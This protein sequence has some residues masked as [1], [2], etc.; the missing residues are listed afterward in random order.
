LSWACG[1]ADLFVA[2]VEILERFHLLDFAIGGGRYSTPSMAHYTKIIPR[3]AFVC[4]NTQSNDFNTL[5]GRSAKSTWCLSILIMRKHNAA[6][7]SK[8]YSRQRQTLVAFHD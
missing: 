6:P 4:L 1:M 3:S 5:I 7:C 8:C 2:T